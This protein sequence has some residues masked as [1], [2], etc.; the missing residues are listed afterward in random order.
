[1]WLST[2]VQEF[3]GYFLEVL[4]RS[5]GGSCRDLHGRLACRGACNFT[6]RYFDVA[7]LSSL[8]CRPN[9]ARP[10][11]KPQKNSGPGGQAEPRLVPVCNAS[12]PCPR[13]CRACR[14]CLYAS[15]QLSEL[16]VQ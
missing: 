5:Q 7:R 13:F 8:K 6:Q 16:F 1:M 10:F 9:P 15:P 3:S 2:Y 4:G 11:P 12:F 14:L